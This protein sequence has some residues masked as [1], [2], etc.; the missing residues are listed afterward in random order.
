MLLRSLLCCLLSFIATVPML[1]RDLTFHNLTGKSLFITLPGTGVAG[2][3]PIQF[4]LDDE[5]SDI[6]SVQ[7]A[8]V[9]CIQCGE[10]RHDV[11]VKDCESDEYRIYQIEGEEIMLMAPGQVL[12]SGSLSLVEW[13]DEDEKTKEQE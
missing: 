1:A 7:D 12:C 5:K 13:S 9:L 3:L 11:E 8:D 2:G 6:F 10:M 4:R